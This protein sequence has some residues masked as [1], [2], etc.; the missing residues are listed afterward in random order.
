MATRPD[1]DGPTEV[2]V[3]AT[4]VDVLDICEAEESFQVE[5]WIS[6]TWTDERLAVGAKTGDTSKD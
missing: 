1:P 6:A 5:A 4:I 3:I 2:S